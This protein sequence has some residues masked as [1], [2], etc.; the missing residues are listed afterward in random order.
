MIM[1]RTTV[2]KMKVITECKSI[3]QSL[4]DPSASVWSHSLSCLSE[5]VKQR[6][7]IPTALRRAA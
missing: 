7:F 6:A 1:A 5:R 2:G 4:V 3:S